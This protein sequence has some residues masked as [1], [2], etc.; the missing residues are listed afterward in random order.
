MSRRRAAITGIGPITCIGH[1]RADFWNGILAEKSG[2][3]GITT[4]DPGAFRVRCAGE[5][6]EWDPEEFF[7]AHRL[8]RLDRYAQFA[9]A[10]AKLALDDAQ[11]DYSREKPQHRVGVSFGDRKSKRLN[12]R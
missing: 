1:G 5:I 7:P 9:V 2:V 12:S 3:N 6:R 11:F 8:K 4:F 10:S